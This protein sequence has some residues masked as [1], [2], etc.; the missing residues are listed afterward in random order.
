MS[1]EEKNIK[2]KQARNRYR[3]MSEKE[4]NIKTEYAR[5]RY[6]TMIKVCY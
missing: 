5:N 6:H 4:K 1:E 2:R 3:N